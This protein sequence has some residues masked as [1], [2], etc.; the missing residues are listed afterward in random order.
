MR[1][2]ALLDFRRRNE[3]R[4]LYKKNLII[5]VNLTFRPGC[6]PVVFFL[7]DVGIK[8]IVIF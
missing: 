8:K 2:E 6:C 4:R 1:T 5:N 3:I 7:I